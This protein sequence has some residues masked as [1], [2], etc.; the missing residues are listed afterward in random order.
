MRYH[1]TSAKRIYVIPKAIYGAESVECTEGS[2]PY[3][4]KLLRIGSL[5]YKR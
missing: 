4:F 2:D 3:Y 1:F 5:Y